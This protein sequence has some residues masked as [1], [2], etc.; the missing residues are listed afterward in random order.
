MDKRKDNGDDS[1]RYR[2]TAWVEKVL[3]N[4]KLEYLHNEAH[5]LK[6]ISF[7]EIDPELLSYEINDERCEDFFFVDEKVYNAYKELSETRKRVLYLLFVQEMSITEISKELGIPCAYASNLKY[8]ALKNL[9][10][11]IEK[12]TKDE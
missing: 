1:L 12:E 2:F 10:N 8:Y 5:R 3:K 9:K 6:T 11:N 4:A 7:D